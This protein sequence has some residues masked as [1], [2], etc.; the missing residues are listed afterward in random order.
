MAITYKIYQNGTYLKSVSELTATI[1]GLLPNT[2]YSFQVSETDGEDESAKSTLVEFT[3]G[4]IAVNSITLNAS[5]KS[6]AKGSTFQL[7]VTFDPANATDKTIT[8]TSSAPTIASVSSGGLISG[9]KSGSATITAKT[10]NG[11]TATCAITVTPTVK[12]PTNLV[13]SEITATSATLTWSKGV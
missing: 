6:I 2:K 12:V 9:L 10:A 13:A 1:T 3:T 11:K 7:S 4:S 8:W 5:S